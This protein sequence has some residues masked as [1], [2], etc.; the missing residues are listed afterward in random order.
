MKLVD[1]DTDPYGEHDKPD[2]HQDEGETISLTEG[3]AIGGGSSWE[4]EQETPFRGTSL[5]MKVL[6]ERIEGLY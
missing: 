2:E 3:R 5:R 6:R 4:P 1:V